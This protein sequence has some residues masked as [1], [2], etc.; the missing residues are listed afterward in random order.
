MSIK[1][2]HAQKKYG[3]WAWVR[4][5]KLNTQNYFYSLINKDPLIHKIEINPRIIFLFW[6]NLAEQIFSNFYAFSLIHKAFG[7]FSKLKKKFNFKTLDNFKSLL[8][9]KEGYFLFPFV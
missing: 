4:V 6:A 5:Q 1:N 9:V 3:F 2:I 7:T 8:K